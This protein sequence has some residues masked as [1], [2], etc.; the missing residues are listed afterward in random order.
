MKNFS[1]TPTDKNALELL[2]IDPI[3]RNNSVFRFIKLIDT[4]EGG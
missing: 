4:V 2:R 1:I 3:N